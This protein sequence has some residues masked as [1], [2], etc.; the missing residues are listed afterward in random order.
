ML[1]LNRN[2]DNGRP[3]IKVERTAEGT[4]FEI[5]IAVLN[6]IMWGLIAWLWARLPEQIPVHLDVTGRPDGY[7][8]RWMIV[9]TGAI[10]TLIS[11]LMCFCAYRPASAISLPVQLKNPAQLAAAVR[12]VR[13]LGVMVSLMF[14]SIVWSMGGA[15]SCGKTASGMLTIVI[16][17]VVLVAYYTARIRKLR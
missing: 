5:T 8:G 4:A 2:N 6:I 12:M 13:I 15:A 9:V 11:A 17:I 3:R 14:V 16:V 7:G 1:T 10:G